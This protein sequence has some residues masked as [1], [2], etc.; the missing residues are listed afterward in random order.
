VG[1]A[2]VGPRDLIRLARRHRK[3]FG[4]GMRQCGIIAAGALY[5]LEHHVQRL[6]EDH[7]HARLLA[8]AIAQANGVSLVHDHVETNI[9]FF[10]VDPRLGSAR[11]LVADLRQEG[12]LMLAES[13]RRVRALTHLDVSRDDVHRAGQILQRVADRAAASLV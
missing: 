12:V 5:A 1:S 3:L 6:A 13:D 9:V 11:K 4:G 2:L 8:E 7:E 10:D